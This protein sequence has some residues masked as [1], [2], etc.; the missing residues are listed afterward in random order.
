M[1]IVCRSHGLVVRDGLV[2][3]SWKFVPKAEI[4]H[5]CFVCTKYFYRKLT[6]IQQQVFRVFCRYRESTASVFMS[7]RR[8]PQGRI[9]SLER[10]HRW[11]FTKAQWYEC[12]YCPRCVATHTGSAEAYYNGTSRDH[13]SYPKGTIW[14]HVGSQCLYCCREICYKKR[15]QDAVARVPN[16]PLP[17]A[18]QTAERLALEQLTS[19]LAVLEGRGHYP[20]LPSSFYE[21]GGKDVYLRFRPIPFGGIP[22][23]W[24]GDLSRLQL[25]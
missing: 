3:T 8:K 13:G 16:I 6:E 24:F 18:R 25:L 14:G 1:C 5:I 12:G 22:D 17:S 20:F 10:R 21:E 11:M 7:N 9:F 4:P 19:H 2:L 15:R 23:A